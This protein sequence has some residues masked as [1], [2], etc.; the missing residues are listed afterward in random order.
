MALAPSRSCGT[1]AKFK[2]CLG[3]LAG[4]RLPGARQDVALAPP[5]VPLTLQHPPVDTT[6]P[7]NLHGGLG[8][9]SC[10]A[11]PHRLRQ[12]KA[13][14]RIVGLCVDPPAHAV[15]VSVEKASRPRSTAP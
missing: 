10:A 13:L 3:P 12:V 6:A 5:E 11:Q 1:P 9:R 8:G 7:D 14:Q 4:E 2:T 15:V